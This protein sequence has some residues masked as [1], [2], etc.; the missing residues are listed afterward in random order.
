MPFYRIEDFK[1]H[2]FNPHLSTGEGPVIEGQYMYFRIVTKRAGTGSKLHY[3]PN[4]LM[5]FPLSGKINAM[6]GKD[7]R[8]VRPGTFVHIPPY[9]RHGFTATEDG[10]LHYLY[11]K[12]RTWTLIGSAEDE[13]LPEQARSANEVARDFAA[14]TY[15]GKEKAPEKSKAIVE[16]L[17]NCYYPMIESLEAPPAS[18]H[19]SAGWR[20]R[21][22][23][24]VSSRRQATPQAAA[25]RARTVCLRHSGQTRCCHRRRDE[26]GR[27]RG[28][29]LC[30]QGS[31]LCL[32]GGWF[33]E[34]TL[35]RRALHA[36]SGGRDR[37][38]R[39]RGQLAGLKRRGM[40]EYRVSRVRT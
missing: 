39:R 9:A 8:I 6:V 7:R 28:C 22:S 32:D 25:C 36:A 10:D 38:R 29:R 4:E 13:P 17:G 24:S 33:R 37:S 16:G 12:D 34:R 35:C 3:H 30:S 15:P 19:C 26:A 1:T 11:I 14:G 40:T 21:I 18:G 20:A 5:T 31:G 27:A 2:Q 23:P